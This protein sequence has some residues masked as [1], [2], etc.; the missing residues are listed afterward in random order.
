[1][2]LSGFSSQEMLE[3]LLT[4]LRHSCILHSGS[5]DW[6]SASN[7]ESENIDYRILTYV[8]IYFQW[9]DYTLQ[10]YYSTRSQDSDSIDTH[11]AIPMQAHKYYTTISK[12]F[13]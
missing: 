8:W 1:M 4:S 11:H 3:R 9:T 7:W 2:T 10:Q 6:G 5:L 12:C 13:Y